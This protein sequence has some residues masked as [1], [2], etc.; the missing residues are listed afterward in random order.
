MAGLERGDQVRV[1]QGPYTG[2]AGRVASTAG[3]RVAVVLPVF[4]HH[5]RLEFDSGEVERVQ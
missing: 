5:T 1:V 2:F 4:G 3:E